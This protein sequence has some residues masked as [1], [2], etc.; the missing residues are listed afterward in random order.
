M[1]TSSRPAR[2]LLLVLLVVWLGV[3]GTLG[4]YAGKL[5]EVSTTTGQAAHR[6]RDVE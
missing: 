3:G 5:G 4:S 6:S 1:R 2:W